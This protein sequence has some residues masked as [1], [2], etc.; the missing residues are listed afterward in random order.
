MDFYAKFILSDF[1]SIF[2]WLYH[3]F[4]VTSFSSSITVELWETWCMD[5]VVLV[6]LRVI[7]DLA[8]IHDGYIYIVWYQ[9]DN[10]VFN[11]NSNPERKLYSEEYCMNSHFIQ[12][13][14]QQQEQNKSEKKSSR[15]L[16]NNKILCLG[17]VASIAPA[18][19]H[20][21]IAMT[22]AY[23]IMHIIHCTMCRLMCFNTKGH[24]KNYIFHRIGWAIL[25]QF[26][27]TIF[28]LFLLIL[29]IIFSRSRNYHDNYFCVTGSKYWTLAIM[30]LLRFQRHY[31]HW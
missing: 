1:Y 31:H 11:T 28:Q 8:C 14:Q 23:W 9:T 24:W 17:G 26:S 19:Q 6:C 27:T 3:I 13:K 10:N 7:L 20:S 21:P 30:T 5:R 12:P 29:L 2:W 15:D 4:I 16:T 25:T 22:Y 18:K